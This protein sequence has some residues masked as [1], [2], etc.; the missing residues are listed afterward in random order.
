MS[1]DYDNG[2]KPHCFSKKVASRFQISMRCYTPR[3]M[4]GQILL[5]QQA[6]CPA[7]DLWCGLLLWQSDRRV[8]RDCSTFNVHLQVSGPLTNEPIIL[9]ETT[10]S[11]YS[12]LPPFVSRTLMALAFALPGS[13]SSDD[14]DGAASSA[15][16]GRSG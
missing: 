12:R 15:S 13:S 14:T 16:L 11:H 1:Y 10:H 5:P 9:G 7:L 3:E 2:A 6:V 8:S 4:L